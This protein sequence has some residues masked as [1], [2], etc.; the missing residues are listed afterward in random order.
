VIIAAMGQMTFGTYRIG[1]TSPAQA[2]VLSNLAPKTL[3]ITSISTT[4]DFAQKNT[5][6]TSLAALGTCNIN[7]T[8]K[9]LIKGLR[10][11][12]LMVKDGADNG[13]QVVMLQGTGKV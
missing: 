12:Y 4:G 3:P 11:G 6:G 10:T 7:V 1:T 9:P 8:F 2:T 13:P 5:C